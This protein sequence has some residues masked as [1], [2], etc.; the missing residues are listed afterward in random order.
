MPSGHKNVNQ[1]ASLKKKEKK[2]KKTFLHFLSLTFTQFRE[3]IPDPWSYHKKI[4]A[5]VRL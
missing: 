2:K 4:T 1:H 5:V 3:L